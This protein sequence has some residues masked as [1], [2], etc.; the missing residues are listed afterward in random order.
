MRTV[1]A[2]LVVGAF[3]MLAATPLMAD[4]VHVDTFLNTDGPIGN[5]ADELAFVQGEVG[6]DDLEF[7]AKLGAEGEEEGPLAAFFNVDFDGNTADV[8]WDLTGTG[9][10]VFWILVKDGT[11][12]QDHLYSLWSVTADQLVIGGGTVG[13]LDDEGN[14]IDR[15]VSHVSFF[16]KP[17]N[18]VPEPTTLLLL[19]SG[20]LGLGILRRRL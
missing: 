11:I 10:G 18:G 19:G 15:D 9:F 12:D 14:F 2:F 17:V 1:R 20:L 6:D 8:S 16:G 13:F 5:P 7:L 3:L 4:V